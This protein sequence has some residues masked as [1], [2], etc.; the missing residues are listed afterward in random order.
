MQPARGCSAL[1][2]GPLEEGDRAADLGRMDG[3]ELPAV[4]APR[5]ED[6]LGVVRQQRNGGVLPRGHRKVL[7]AR[8]DV[9]TTAK[10]IP[11]RPRAAR[12]GAGPVAD[13][14][15]DRSTSAASEQLSPLVLVQPA[16]DPMRLAHHQRVLTAFHQH[17]TATADLLRRSLPLEPVLLA[18][19]VVGGEEELGLRPL[20]GCA[21]LPADLQIPCRGRGPSRAI[22]P[23]K[24]VDAEICR[25]SVNLSVDSL[26]PLAVTLRLRPWYL[27]PQ[28]NGA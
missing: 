18:L 26:N 1:A 21:V 15:L 4:L 9:G 5:V 13:Q 2:L 10:A 11:G 3:D 14:S 7:S 24:H 22:G 6:L 8:L 27:T 20:A 25:R 19:E 12:R 28:V 17:R 23:E 16:P